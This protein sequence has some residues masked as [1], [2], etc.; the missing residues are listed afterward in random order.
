MLKYSIEVICELVDRD[1]SP[2]PK[3][4]LLHVSDLIKYVGICDSSQVLPLCYD[5]D[6]KVGTDGGGDEFTLRS[7]KIDGFP[8]AAVP[9]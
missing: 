9:Q 1:E 7:K 5:S 2:L 6:T 8:L 4:N 3:V